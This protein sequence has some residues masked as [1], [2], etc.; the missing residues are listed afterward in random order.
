ML[1]LRI[2]FLVSSSSLF[3]TITKEQK[4]KK[5]SF[6]LWMKMEV[7]ERKIAGRI[8][9]QVIDEEEEEN[10]QHSFQR[11]RKKQPIWQRFLTAA[12]L[13]HTYS[14][15]RRG[16]I[17]YS[18]IQIDLKR[19]FFFLRAGSKFDATRIKYFS[20]KL[21]GFMSCNIYAKCD[22]N[23]LFVKLSDF[24]FSF[25]FFFFLFFFEGC[26]ATHPK[27]IKNNITHTFT[28]PRP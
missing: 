18:N 25:F 23:S 7:E 4:K 21:A 1:D 16:I 13:E 3:L 26:L 11:K 19:I 20:V 9:Y 24:L 28:S 10:H 8:S 15:H 14:C 17:S 12:Q 6:F 22:W 5:I 2:R 27:K